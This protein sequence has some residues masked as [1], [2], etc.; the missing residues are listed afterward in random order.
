MNIINICFCNYETEF[1]ASG[2]SLIIFWLYGDDDV[3][4]VMPTVDVNVKF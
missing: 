1:H 4:K 3:L 2:I